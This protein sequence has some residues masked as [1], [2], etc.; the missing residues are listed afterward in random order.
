MMYR[1]LAAQTDLE[2]ATWTDLPDTSVSDSTSTTSENC[3]SVQRTSNESFQINST[4]DDLIFSVMI[5]DVS[6]TLVRSDMSVS[7]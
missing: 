5:F 4:C 2:D 1:A 6:G 7:A 3:S